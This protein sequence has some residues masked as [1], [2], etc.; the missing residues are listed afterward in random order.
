MSAYLG[1][2]QAVAKIGSTGPREWV[3]PRTFAARGFKSLSRQDYVMS[4]TIRWIPVGALRSPRSTNTD[5]AMVE[6]RTSIRIEGRHGSV[7]GLTWDDVPKFAVI[8]GK[9]DPGSRSS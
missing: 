8:T 4:E 7:G 1:E 3:H 2:T 9:M 5:D 6:H